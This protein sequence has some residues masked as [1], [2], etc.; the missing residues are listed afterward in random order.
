LRH[1][2]GSAITFALLLVVMFAVVG[3]NMMPKVT[4]REAS[5]HGLT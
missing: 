2:E 3:G 5:N 1:H 4:R